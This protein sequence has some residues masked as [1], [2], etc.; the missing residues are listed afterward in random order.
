MPLLRIKASFINEMIELMYIITTR[1][2]LGHCFA[3]GA[4]LFVVFKYHSV[5]RGRLVLCY[6][7]ECHA[8]FCCYLTQE[9]YRRMGER[10]HVNPYLKWNTRLQGTGVWTLSMCSYLDSLSPMSE[11]SWLNICFEWNIIFICVVKHLFG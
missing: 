8:L 1:P 3:D 5:R 2:G 11:I 10:S 7:L 9:R 4:V 6:C